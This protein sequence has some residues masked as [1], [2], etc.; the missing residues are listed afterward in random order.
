[1]HELRLIVI[2]RLIHV[3]SVLKIYIKTEL[4]GFSEIKNHFLTSTDGNMIL[5]FNLL[6]DIVIL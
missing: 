1:M 3:I 5:I 2:L 4:A 6:N